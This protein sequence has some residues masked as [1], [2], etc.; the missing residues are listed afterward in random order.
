MK[1]NKKC[2]A[3]GIPKT[4]FTV[5]KKVSTKAYSAAN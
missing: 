1:G 4:P 5:G 3:V 2:F